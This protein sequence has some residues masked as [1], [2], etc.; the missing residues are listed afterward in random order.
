M[1]EGIKEEW[2]FYRENQEIYS[3]IRDQERDRSHLGVGALST[4]ATASGDG[5]Y[6]VGFGGEGF[7]PIES[8]GS[9]NLG[10]RYQYFA[11]GAGKLWE[12]HR[13]DLLLD[14]PQKYD[15]GRVQGG[16]YAE[17]RSLT[18]E[19]EFKREGH[20]GVLGGVEYDLWRPS[21]HFAAAVDLKAGLG[22]GWP[23]PQQSLLQLGLV[24]AFTE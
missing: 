11:G 20:Y 6:R 1:T 23:E 16:L 4:V 2:P 21:P 8:D 9:L 24:L 17:V 14:L 3:S 5:Y 13:I 15:W 12:G 19:E 18:S 10:L 22:F 7:V